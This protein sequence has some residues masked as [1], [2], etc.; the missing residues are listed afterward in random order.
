MAGHKEA[1]RQK[2]WILQQ[3]DQVTVVSAN[4]QPK[5]E[6]VAGERMKALMG[7]FKTKDEAERRAA[8]TYSRTL[9]AKSERNG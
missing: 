1:A 9:K 2:W 5:L 4:E 8:T 6:H 7:P 3:H